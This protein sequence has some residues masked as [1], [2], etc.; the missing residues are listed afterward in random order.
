M[1]MTKTFF[2]LL[3][4]FKFHICRF[5][6]HGIYLDALGQE[7]VNLARTMNDIIN[8]VTSYESMF[9]WHKYYT[10]HDSRETP[11]TN[12]FCAFCAALNDKQRQNEAKVYK[13]IVK[14]FNE[15]KDWN[16]VPVGSKPKRSAEMKDQ[17]K[18]IHTTYKPKPYVA[19]NIKYPPRPTSA[20]K[21]V[22]DD[23]CTGILSCLKSTFKSVWNSLYIKW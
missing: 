5:M 9:R 11:D 10:Y 22:E 15:R 14:W 19:I 13:N 1:I 23:S 2:F 21:D 17:D 7:P 20:P 8:N 12:N 6:P 4:L 16:V 18:N 3:K